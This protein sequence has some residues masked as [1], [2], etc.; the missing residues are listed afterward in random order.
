[1]RI[2]NPTKD[3]DNDKVWD[4]LLGEIKLKNFKEQIFSELWIKISIDT[5]I[6]LKFKAEKVNKAYVDQN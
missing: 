1:M 3:S 5:L 4:P 6:P 2:G